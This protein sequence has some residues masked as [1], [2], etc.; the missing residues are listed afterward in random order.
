MAF[1]ASRR[2]PQRHKLRL[3]IDR[4][5]RRDLATA[6]LRLA[7]WWIATSEPG[8]LWGGTI[9][10]RSWPQNQRKAGNGRSICSFVSLGLISKSTG[11]CDGTQST[12]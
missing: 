11:E 7:A 3:A 1:V 9:V 10:I 2:E 5:R 4:R 6:E 12:V 8:T